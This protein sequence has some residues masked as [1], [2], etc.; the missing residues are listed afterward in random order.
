MPTYKFP[1]GF[2]WGASTA[3]H[4]VEGGLRD[5][6]TNWEHK[7]STRLAQEAKEKFETISPI[8]EEIASEANDP[9]TYISGQGVEHW[10]LF[11][12][13]VELMRELNFTAYRFSIDWSRIEP[14]EGKYNTAVIQEYASMVSL[15]KKQ[16][17]EP[18]V[19]LWH[20]T[21]PQWFHDKGGWEW[22]GAPDAFSK[23]VAAITPELS[24]SVKFWI[25]LNEPNVYTASSYLTGAWPPQKRSIVAHERVLRALSHA[26]ERVRKVIKET[27]PSAQV[28]ISQH[29]TDIQ[30]GDNSPITNLHQ[31]CS[32]WAWNQRFLNGIQTTT[33]FIGAN[34]YG[35]NTIKGLQRNQ[36]ENKKVSDLGWEL[37]PPA[38][39]GALR[40]AASYD[41]PIYITENGLADQRDLNREWYIKETLMYVHKAL[42]EGIDV[43]GY[44]H[45]SLL[46]NF[47]W[48]KGFWPK[49]GLI[50]VDRK[51]LKRTI[52]PSAR[53]YSAIIKDNGFSA[54]G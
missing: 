15:L 11:H 16:G 8:W 46:D 12:S 42:A 47:E 37:Y 32:N 40:I 33:D 39:L 29:L 38:T 50:A 44:L 31:I 23:F 54:L 49:F 41:K 19:T 17:I 35:R 53:V 30:A 14:Q 25:T 20:W 28:G 26:H 9:Q 24:K 34:I 52:R 43:R 18:F 5:N 13:D 1:D 4:Q 3:S 36:N 2:L 10:K 21:V 22:D 27:N 7:N 48:D 45:W 6:W 51:T